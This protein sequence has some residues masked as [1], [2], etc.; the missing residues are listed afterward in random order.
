[1]LAQTTQVSAH[2]QNL[3]QVCEQLNWPICLFHPL[4]I[5]TCRI[6][7]LAI[8]WRAIIIA[9]TQENVI[10]E[11]H[12]SKIEAHIVVLC[13]PVVQVQGCCLGKVL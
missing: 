9:T 6:T 7:S 8:I 1:M 4:V 12:A 3:A 5:V 11:A 2:G 13:V 10:V